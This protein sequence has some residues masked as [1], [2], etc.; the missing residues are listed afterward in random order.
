MEDKIYITED[1]FLTLQL[2]VGSLRDDLELAAKSDYVV[3]ELIYTRSQEEFQKIFDIINRIQKER[4]E[5]A[6]A[7]KKEMEDGGKEI[8]EYIKEKE[9]KLKRAEK[10]LREINAD[11]DRINAEY[12]L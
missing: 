7:F 2:A 11:L 5:K 4:H 12:E 6:E 1:E 3:K 10:I 9:E 8:Y